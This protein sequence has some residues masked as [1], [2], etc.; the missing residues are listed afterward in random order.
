MLSGLPH[1]FQRL[2]THTT[3]NSITSGHNGVL[4]GAK[5]MM[6]WLRRLLRFRFGL[7][8]LPRK[9]NLPAEESMA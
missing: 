2:R 3:K 7:N 8:N 1:A 4:C 9:E 6:P 5:N